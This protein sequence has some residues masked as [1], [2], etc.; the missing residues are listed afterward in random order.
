M[1][2]VMYMLFSGSVKQKLELWICCISSF[3]FPVSDWM[4][5]A[6]LFPHIVFILDVLYCLFLFSDN[7]I[8]TTDTF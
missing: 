7:L 8:I 5:S 2:T 6:T 4:S 1:S 3:T